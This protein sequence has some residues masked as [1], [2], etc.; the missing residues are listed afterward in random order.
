[1]IIDYLKNCSLFILLGVSVR[2]VCTLL[3]SDYLIVFLSNNLITLLI[4]LLAINTT[5]G[6]VVMTKLREIVERHGGNFS[7]TL[8]QLKLS[9]VEQLAF[10]VL[11]VLILILLGSK[12][13]LELNEYIKP[14]LEAG[15]IS[16]FIASL[17]NLYDTASSIFVI[18]AWEG[19][20]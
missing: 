6:S 3:E 20:Q 16:V 7:L 5:T 4:A 10:I 11:A 12:P 13:T 14:L 19:G 8:G 15:L 17:H 2:F 9:I 1:M 18:L